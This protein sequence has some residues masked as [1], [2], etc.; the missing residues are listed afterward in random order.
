MRIHNPVGERRGVKILAVVVTAVIVSPFLLI[1]NAAL[2]SP[3]QFASDTVLALANPPT[4][5]NLAALLTGD[6]PMVAPMGT[7]LW[8]SAV[9]VFTQIPVSLLAGYVF[10]T[11]AFPLRQALFWALITLWAIPPIVTV[12]PLYVMMVRWGI[13]GSAWA[14]V[15]PVL[16]LSPYAVFLLRQHIL[17]LPKE[18]IDQARIDGASH[19]RVV[20]SIIVPMSK[21]VVMFLVLVTVV[22][23]WN[24]YLWP[25]I[26]AG[27]Q[28]PMVTVFIHSLHTQYQSRWTLVMAATLIAALPLLA[29]FGIAQKGIRQ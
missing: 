18:L 17:D 10:A 22:T 27:S 24:W 3:E 6:R 29:S 19:G 15:L 26:V 16:F 4:G 13:A 12:I 7:T 8:V 1:V 2:M 23:Q 5:D 9:L 28:N 14:I 25:R 11:I 20:W 21:T